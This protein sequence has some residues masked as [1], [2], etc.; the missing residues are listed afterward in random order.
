MRRVHLADKVNQ[1]GGVSAFCSSSI[2]P[3]AI[4]LRV[5]TW[6]NRREAVTCEACLLKLARFARD[7][8][9]A[10]CPPTSGEGG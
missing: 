1:H 8:L 6:T 2:R 9:A 4:N 7:G 5:A 3:R 10:P